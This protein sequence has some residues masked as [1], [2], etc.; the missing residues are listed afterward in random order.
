MNKVA[1]RLAVSVFLI[2]LMLFNSNK[3]LC[4]EK[5]LYQEK[6]GAIELVDEDL[7]K[8]PVKIIEFYID[9]L[10]IK[11]TE[12][13]FSQESTKIKTRD[14]QPTSYSYVIGSAQK[15]SI[16]IKLT[17][18]IE[19]QVGIKIKIEVMLEDK[20]LK[21]EIISTKNLEPV[22]VELLEHKEKDE[23]YADRI[24]PLIRTIEPPKEYPDVIEEL[25]FEDNMFLLNQEVISRNSGTLTVPGGTIDKPIFIGIFVRGK[26]MF[27][28]SLNPFEG[29]EPIGVAKE[30]IMKFK[31]NDDLIEFI[32]I[33]PFIKKGKWTVWVRMNPSYDPAMDI[34]E[35]VAGTIR[36]TLK[37]PKKYSFW[38]G[39]S[40]EII[41]RVFGNKKDQ[42]K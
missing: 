23:K 42:T 12:T 10:L 24:T 30:N 4:Q 34:P 2:A 39:S 19:E 32:S 28:M 20:I 13:I 25:K 27:V 26:G 11:P 8:E 9:H 14:G 37:K 6:G 36:E 3:S 1:L 21:E 41:E 38:F 31:Y 17:P 18:F 7:I 16:Q 22:I 29:A 33:K 40:R 15:A 35:E 5:I